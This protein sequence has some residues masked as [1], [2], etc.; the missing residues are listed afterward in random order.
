MC[1][2]GTAVAKDTGNCVAVPRGL[3]M[4][5]VCSHN[6]IS[7]GIGRFCANSVGFRWSLSLLPHLC[8]LC[9]PCGGGGYVGYIRK[10]LEKGYSEHPG[11]ACCTDNMFQIFVRFGRYLCCSLPLFVNRQLQCL[12]TNSHHVLLLP[13]MLHRSLWFAKEH[14]LGVKLGRRCPSSLAGRPRSLV[15]PVHSNLHAPT[16]STRF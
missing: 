9:V 10:A 8:P 16:R 15:Q 5:R 6:R 14:A 3:G 4:G 2:H 12:H 1:G 11:S 13:P 7:L